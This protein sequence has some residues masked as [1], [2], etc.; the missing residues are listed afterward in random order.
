MMGGSMVIWIIIALFI[1]GIMVFIVNANS[2]TSQQTR[3]KP[4]EIDWEAATDASVQQHLPKGKIQAIKAYRQLTGLG[5][6][7]AKEAVEYVM[8]NPDALDG[9]RRKKKAPSRDA[10]VRELVRQGKI[11]E[12]V[13]IYRDFTGASLADAKDDIAQIKQELALEDFGEDEADSAYMS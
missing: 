13:E 2:A 4:L 12:A 9:A 8:D 6:K 11:D 10:G 7:E 1:V 5:L 3:K